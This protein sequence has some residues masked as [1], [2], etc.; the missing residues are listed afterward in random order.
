MGLRDDVVYGERIGDLFPAMFALRD[1]MKVGRDG[2][3]HM[4]ATFDADVG[5]P[6]RRALMRAEAELLL[7][8]AATV[9]TPQNMDRTHEQRS[10]DALVRLA[11]A[12]GAHARASR[13][14]RTS[15]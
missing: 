1:S 7:E 8:D 15:S 9:G 11:R 13:P 4:S 5:S 14:R 12:L 6:L 2:R 10:A 3:C